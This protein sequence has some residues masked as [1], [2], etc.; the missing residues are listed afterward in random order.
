M[1]DGSLRGDG[2][3][4]RRESRRPISRKLDAKSGRADF[5]LL[6]I[7]RLSQQLGLRDACHAFTPIRNHDID[8]GEGEFF[9]Q[10]RAGGS[11]PSVAAPGSLLSRAASSNRT[12][13]PRLQLCGP[14]TI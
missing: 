1:E 5:Q 14:F 10:I 6:A 9:A 4:S 8:P 2:T 11:S 7:L 3:R 13:A 12:S